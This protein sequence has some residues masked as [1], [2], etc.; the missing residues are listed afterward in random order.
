MSS[1]IKGQKYIG[2]YCMVCGYLKEVKEKAGMLVCKRCSKRKDFKEK[3][4]TFEENAKKFTGFGG[5]N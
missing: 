1:R 2:E 3:L 5:P 4:K